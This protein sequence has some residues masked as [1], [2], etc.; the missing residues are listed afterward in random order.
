MTR[1]LCLEDGDSSFLQNTVNLYQ[2]T[3]HYILEDI[4]A[5]HCHKNLKGKGK[6]PVHTLKAYGGM[7]VQLHS[8]LTSELRGGEC[9]LCAAA[10]LHSLG[11]GPGTQ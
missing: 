7:E 3:W 2:T 1:N 8:F 9:C 5:I 11:G 4:L 6:V 10:V